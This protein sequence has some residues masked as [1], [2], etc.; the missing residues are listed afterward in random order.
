[1]GTFGPGITLPYP[2]GGLCSA[3]HLYYR[4]LSI[5]DVLVMVVWDGNYGYGRSFRG[6]GNPFMAV[7][8][9][10]RVREDGRLYTVPGSAYCTVCALRVLAFQ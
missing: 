7:L 3:I 1:M 4:C 5:V 10:P 2:Q 6:P 8:L 9:R